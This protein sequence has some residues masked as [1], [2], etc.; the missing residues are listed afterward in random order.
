[1][2]MS[3]RKNEV[4]VNDNVFNNDLSGLRDKLGAGMAMTMTQKIKVYADVEYSKGDGIER[5]L[6]GSVGGII[7]GKF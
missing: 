5:P 7:V 3:S 4:N 2:R 1:M 6:G